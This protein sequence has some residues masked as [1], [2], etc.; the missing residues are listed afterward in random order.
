MPPD[1]PDLTVAYCGR[2]QNKGTFLPSKGFS[3]SCCLASAWLEALCCRSA[4]HHSFAGARGTEMLFSAAALGF[5]A[6]HCRL[7]TGHE[8]PWGLGC[9]GLCS[10]S[11]AAQ[12]GKNISRSAQRADPTPVMGE[13]MPRASGETTASTQSCGDCGWWHGLIK[14]Q[15][16]AG[17][18][19][20][21]RKQR[22][23]KSILNSRCFWFQNSAGNSLE[24]TTSVP[25]EVSTDLQYHK[26]L[27]HSFLVPY[28]KIISSNYEVHILPF[29]DIQI[30]MDGQKGIKEMLRSQRLNRLHCK[31]GISLF[32][33]IPS[34]PR[35]LPW[36]SEKI[37]IPSL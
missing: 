10:G 36:H 4:L 34:L 35:L 13:T 26:L 6:G 14:E 5:G 12:A 28:L 30:S 9:R 33:T 25:S 24:M 11:A 22:H 27:W 16:L 18:A 7:G 32:Q 2:N 29:R 19:G 17:R 23:P 20:R 31:G 8:S 3:T 21:A 37:Y 1:A 15:R